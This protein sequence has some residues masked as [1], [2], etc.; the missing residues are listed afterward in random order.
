M[1]R[2][3]IPAPY[4]D[5]IATYQKKDFSEARALPAP[6]PSETPTE[7][8]KHVDAITFQ[9]IRIYCRN[10]KEVDTLLDNWKKAAWLET[11]QEITT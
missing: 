8:V 11:L 2:E 9:Q 5:L 4:V 6:L 3:T 1:D 10:I 7:H